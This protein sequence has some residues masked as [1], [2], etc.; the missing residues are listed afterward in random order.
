VS[1]QEHV[2]HEE[3]L[4]AVQIHGPLTAQDVTTVMTK[5]VK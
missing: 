3:V 1:G 2:S 5:F 4:H